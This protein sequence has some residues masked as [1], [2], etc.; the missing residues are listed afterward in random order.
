MRKLSRKEKKKRGCDYCMYMQKK[1]HYEKTEKSNYY[2]KAYL[3][4]FEECPFHELDKYETY[5]EY[6]K[7]PDCIRMKFNN[8]PTN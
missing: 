4:M 1:K 8:V 2:K 5:D 7:S 6:L 3:C